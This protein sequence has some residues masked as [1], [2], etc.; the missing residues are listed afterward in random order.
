MAKKKLIKKIN[1]KKGHR[2][3]TGIMLKEIGKAFVD[4]KRKTLLDNFRRVKK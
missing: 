4:P 2:M 3:K 1:L